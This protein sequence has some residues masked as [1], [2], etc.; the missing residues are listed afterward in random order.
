M[1]SLSYIICMDF[2]W[3]K[4]RGELQNFI[5]SDENIDYYFHY[6]WLEK[7]LS[8]KI[9]KGQTIRKAVLTVNIMKFKIAVWKIEQHKS[10]EIP[11]NKNY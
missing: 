11:T 3:L 6:L 1:R 5:N 9:Q 4:D 2:R 8:N 7:T 10:G